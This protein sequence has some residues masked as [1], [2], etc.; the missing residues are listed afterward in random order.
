MRDF[1]ALRSRGGGPDLVHFL[2]GHPV[3]HR[4]SPILLVGALFLFS[5][6]SERGRC[7]RGRSE[8]PIFPVNSSFFFALV[9]SAKSKRGRREGDGKK[10]CHDNLR[11]RVGS[12][13]VGWGRV[14]PLSLELCRGHCAEVQPSPR[15][16]CELTISEE[17]FQVTPLSER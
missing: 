2:R 6:G 13:L 15:G 11:S 10:K 7:R 16:E 4:L 1:G 12:K 8:I 3:K 9:L 5:G 17:S 14:P